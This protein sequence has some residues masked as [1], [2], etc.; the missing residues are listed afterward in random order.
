M[1]SYNCRRTQRTTSL[2]ILFGRVNCLPV[3]ASR[4]RILTLSLRPLLVVSGLSVAM[5]ATAQTAP[6][7]PFTL[8]D[9]L[10][11]R[12]FPIRIKL[13]DLPTNAQGVEIGT[14]AFNMAEVMNGPMAMLGGMMG[15]AGEYIQALTKN[16]TDGTEITMGGQRFL[17]TY[18]GN[19]QFDM[20][21][22][23]GSAM[24]GMFRGDDEDE[25]P[26]PTPKPA[27]Y[28]TLVLIRVDQIAT[29]APIGMDKTRLLELRKALDGGGGGK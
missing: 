21:S 25:P 13:E 29:F 4:Y 12:A 3:N 10:G 17:V 8:A 23:M 2:T 16:W 15:P 19:L 20:M 14:S 1:N 22:M 26:P 9:I 28:M 18:R 24:G 6:P 11:G 27:E 5:V 7:T